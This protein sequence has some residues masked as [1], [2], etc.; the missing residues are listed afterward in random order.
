M[1]NPGKPKTSPSQNLKRRA[2]F[3]FRTAQT[4]VYE[5]TAVR[6]KNTILLT[7]LALVVVAVALVWR[8]LF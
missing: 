3:S 8:Y 7:T 2:T 5:R 4:K 6:G 1:A